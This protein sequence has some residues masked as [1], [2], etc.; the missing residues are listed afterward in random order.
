[1]LVVNS[2]T[3]P[4]GGVARRECASEED[5]SEEDKGMPGKVS[6]KMVVTV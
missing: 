1:M 6:V 5:A 4:V 2:G 3:W